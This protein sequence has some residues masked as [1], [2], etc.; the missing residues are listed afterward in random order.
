MRRR[1]RLSRVFVVSESFVVADSILTL[2]M[3]LRKLESALVAVGLFNSECS[4]ASRS[5]SSS[6]ISASLSYFVGSDL[7]EV[8]EDQRRDNIK[9]RAESQSFDEE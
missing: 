8:S 1:R 3:A 5:C 6:C 9:Q 2:T 4:W 7:L